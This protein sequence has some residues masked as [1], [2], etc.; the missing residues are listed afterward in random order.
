[1]PN[2]VRVPQPSLQAGARFRTATECAT[3]AALRIGTVASLTAK[4][5][6]EYLLEAIALLRDRGVRCALFLAGDGPERA[7]LEALVGERRLRPCVQ[8]L[9][10]VAPVAD[11]LDAIDL[12]VLPSRVEGLPLALLEAMLAGKPVVATAVGG[13]PDVIDSGATGVLVAPRDAGALAD[14]IERL[15]AS[16]EL[17]ARLAS[18]ACQQAQQHHS[19]AAYVSALAALYDELLAGSAQ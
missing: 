2:G 6:H 16:P 8:F 5:G 11:L 9:G 7:R 12:F 13:V 10:N 18:A 19:E 17:R 14:A 3:G 4:K 1:V 15:A